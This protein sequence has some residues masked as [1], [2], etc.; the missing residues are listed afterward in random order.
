MLLLLLSVV[1]NSVWPH[2]LQ[3]TRLL[4]PWDFPG[5]STGVGCH[6]ILW[7]SAILECK[8][9]CSLYLSL[10]ANLIFKNFANMAPSQ[11]VGEVMRLQSKNGTRIQ[12][13]CLH[14]PMP[15]LTGDH[16]LNSWSLGVLICETRV[17]I[18]KIW[19]ISIF[20]CPLS[21]SFRSTH[22]SFPRLTF[23]PLFL[24]HST[25]INWLLAS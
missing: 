25:S 10:A 21:L 17:C 23:L 2:G 7:E 14:P 4:F 20:T 6:C 11:M 5:K 24:S 18:Y 12:A 9:Q 22:L 13:I 1:S 3:P 16:R 19:N 8:Y 15:P